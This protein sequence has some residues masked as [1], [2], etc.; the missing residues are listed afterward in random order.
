[1]DRVDRQVVAGCGLDRV[2]QAVFVDPELRGTVAAVGEARVVARAGRRVD[3]QP[4]RPSG[5]PP[6]DPFDLA[7]GVEVEVD[8]QRED[9]VEVALRE[10]RA[11]VADLLWRPAA[12][13]RAGDLAR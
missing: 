7:D 11:G 9:R 1:M 4:D 12:L 13:D 10:V 3:A 8:R 5:R 2:G 6:P